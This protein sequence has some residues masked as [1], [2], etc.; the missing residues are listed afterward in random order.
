[1]DP[2]PG[3]PS[4]R[5]SA[6][7]L[8]LTLFVA[9]SIV[10]G[11]TI[12]GV[13]YWRFTIP[14][15]L[16]ESVTIIVP[17]GAGTRVI[18]GQLSASGI[19]HDP[20]SFLAGA[21][22]LGDAGR[23]K[24]G[25][26]TFAARASGRDVLAKLV[27]GDAVIR[28]LT[29]AEGLTTAQILAQ[30]QAAEG[31]DGTIGP[32]PAEGDLLPE[33]YYYRYGDS[34]ADAVARM[35]RGMSE[36]LAELWAKR[37]PDL[38]LSSPAQAVV[39]ASIVEKETGLAAERGRIAGVFYNRLRLGMRLQSDPTVIYGLTGGAGPLDR[40]LVRADLE[41]DTPYN[42]YARD[43][44]PPGPIANPG[45]QSLIAVLNPEATDELYFVAD[46]NGG[47]VFA[48]TLAEHNRNVARWRQIR[49]Q[50]GGQ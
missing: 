14:G 2:E 9:V 10:A 30:I 15:P 16:P 37:A 49:N 11:A 29:I 47:H 42:T 39:L 24:A 27:A 44:L 20:W 17:R 1:M 43:G 35:R 26:Y 40:P 46:G 3:T 12:T 23:I 8:A 5:R 28:R 31:L 25:E 33:T 41:R 32:R 38:P 13:A 48:K 4:R 36:T 19:I 45:R 18:A 50:G 6:F 34:R 22:A 7:L 21:V